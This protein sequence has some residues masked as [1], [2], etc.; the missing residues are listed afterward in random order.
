MPAGMA[1]RVIL[2]GV[3]VMSTA[4][5]DRRFIR[6]RQRTPDFVRKAGAFDKRKAKYEA[7]LTEREA[8]EEWAQD[9]AGEHSVFE[10]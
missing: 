5:Q 10:D 8:L 9:Y 6:T 3:I 7:E 4:K 2:F 1:T